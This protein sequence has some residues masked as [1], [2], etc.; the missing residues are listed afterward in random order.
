MELT[1][2]SLVMS[3]ETARGRVRTLNV[4]GPKPALEAADVAVAAGRIVA[5]NIFDDS[6]GAPGALMALVGAVREEVRSRVL[7]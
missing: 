5:A 3:F 7:I 2:D 6:P 1:R 4:P